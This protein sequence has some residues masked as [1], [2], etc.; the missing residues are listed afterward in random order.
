MENRLDA[1]EKRNVLW[2]D[3]SD[4]CTLGLT[5]Q[6]GKFREKQS[7]FVKFLTLH[8]FVTTEF[9]RPSSVEYYNEKRVFE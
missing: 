4:L 9:L 2:E 3:K 8:Y 6:E 5:M 7:F 1:R